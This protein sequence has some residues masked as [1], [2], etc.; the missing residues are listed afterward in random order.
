LAVYFYISHHAC[1]KCLYTRKPAIFRKCGY[2]IKFID[3]H[4]CKENSIPH[5][6]N[7]INI[8]GNDGVRVAPQAPQASP[9]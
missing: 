7:N 3:K 5:V 9:L 8:C 2:Q 6:R 1:I 4:I